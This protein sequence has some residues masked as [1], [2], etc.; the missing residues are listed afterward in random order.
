[1]PPEPNLPLELLDASERDEILASAAPERLFLRYWTAREAYLKAQRRGLDTELSAVRA[2]R[3]EDVV[4]L[5][6][7]GRPPATAC[8]V[9]REDAIAAIVE[10]TD[11]H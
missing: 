7:T 4:V 1:M 5:L 8:F 9:E 3:R 10:L 2:S 11:A 6:E